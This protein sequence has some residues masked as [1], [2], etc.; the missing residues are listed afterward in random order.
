MDGAARTVEEW[1]RHLG[2]Q[3][4]ELRRREGKTQAALAREANVSISALHALEHG[5]GS[6]LSTVVSVVRALGRT[7]WL[8]ELAPPVTVSPMAL[9]RQA[10]KG[11]APRA[12]AT[13]GAAP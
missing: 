3:A 11:S 2:A 4:R 6:S 5:T 8:S 9:L 10:Q 7:D 1:E 12:R 13:E